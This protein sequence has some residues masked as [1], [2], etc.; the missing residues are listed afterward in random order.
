VSFWDR[1]TGKIVDAAGLGQKKRAVA[2]GLT[3]FDEP[4]SDL[5]LEIAIKSHPWLQNSAATSLLLSTWVAQ[6]LSDMAAVLEDAAEKQLGEQGKIPAATY[7]LAEGL[8][9]GALAWIDRAQT[10]LAA[11]D[12]DPDFVLGAELPAR[13]PSLPWVADAPPAHFV[14][15]IRAV[16]QLGTSVEDALITVQTDHSGL[17]GRYDGALATITTAVKLARAKLDQVEAAESAQQAVRLGQDIWVLLADAVRLFFTAGQQI[18]R[19]AIID[20]RYDAVAA[21]QAR[22]RRLPPP[23][24]QRAQ[25]QPGAAPAP[26][27]ATSVAGGAASQPGAWDAPR[28]A[29]APAPPPPPP[30]P[31]P[32][33]LG[34][35]LGLSFDAWVLTDADARS[36]YQRDSARI[37]ELEEFWRADPNPEET[38]RLFGL[39]TAAIGAG[40]VAA[41]PREFGRSCPW[42]ASFVALSDVVIG[43]EPFEK[44]QLFT[45][46]VGMDGKY[47]GRGFD[48]LGF[49][50]GA[51]QGK[52]K[53]AEPAAA[54]HI[55]VTHREEH[56]RQPAAGQSVPAVPSGEEMWCLTAAFQRPQRR[57]DKADTEQ[58]RRLWLA[59]PDPR[60]TIAFH[61]EILAAGQAGQVRQHGDEAL[62]DCPW[63]QV[64]VAASQVTIGGV[65]LTA[66][67]KFA[68][69]VGVAGGSFRRSIIRLGSVQ[70]SV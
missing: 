41:R 34:E 11:A 12:T 13:A 64:Y 48:R 17:P 52:P 31:P 61:D 69:Q 68:L 67:E 18:A 19:P 14:A 50:P 8:Y 15:V 36:M 21:A 27:P 62:R 9:E 56:G 24:A 38:N 60:S 29:A 39:V 45:L 66:N 1:A 5:R 35:R 57:A 55:D 28:P 25:A 65:Q 70:A 51:Q 6:A 4:L 46:R 23:P 54:P 58:L 20:S 53:A 32:P 37:A 16:G 44:G 33:T 47:F 42:I 59:D 30:P 10:A 3:A 7:S 43:S 2:T 26:A 49:V 40:T 63:S 22:S